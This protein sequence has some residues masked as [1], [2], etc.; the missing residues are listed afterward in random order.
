MEKGQFFCQFWKLW[1]CSLSEC[2]IFAHRGQLC[3][4]LDRE[5]VASIPTWKIPKHSC[6][7]HH[8]IFLM[9]S[10]HSMARVGIQQVLVKAY[11][12]WDSTLHKIMTIAWID[13]PLDPLDLGHWDSA[14]VAL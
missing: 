2:E 12:R 6:M 5:H 4:F 1:F 9:H 8:N 11:R 7:N 10:F 3:K 14:R 13:E